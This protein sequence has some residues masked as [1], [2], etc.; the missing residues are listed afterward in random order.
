MRSGGR[1]YVAK[2]DK[3]A[4]RV[5]FQ[6]AQAARFLLDR[7]FVFVTLVFSDMPLNDQILM[8]AA[9]TVHDLQCAGTDQPEET[10]CPAKG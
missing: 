5:M 3:A 10:V 1:C 7:V 8:A 9:L 4:L 6:V 2:F